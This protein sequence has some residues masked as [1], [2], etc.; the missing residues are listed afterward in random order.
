[1]HQFH[2]RRVV[3]NDQAVELPTPA[4]QIAQQFA[5]RGAGDAGE[6]VKTTITAPAPAS[7]AALNAGS[8]TLCI[9]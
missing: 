4:Q 9:R 8:T 2:D 5:M 7:T 3:G 6:I 1:M